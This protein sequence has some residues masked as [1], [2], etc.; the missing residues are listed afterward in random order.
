MAQ[1]NG[2]YC[3]GCKK[4]GEMTQVLEPPSGWI[5]VDIC[6]LAGSARVVCGTTC[7]QKW[8]TARKQENAKPKRK[9]EETAKAFCQANCSTE[10]EFTTHHERCALA[11]AWT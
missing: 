4:V 8:L 1:F 7:C 10:G 11:P 5:R 9:K 2:I 6:G 3:D